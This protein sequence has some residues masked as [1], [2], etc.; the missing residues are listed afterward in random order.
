MKRISGF[1]IGL[2][3]LGMAF[4][5]FRRSQGGWEAGFADIGVWWAVIAALLV[6][7]A[8]G[9]LVGTWLHTRTG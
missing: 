9:A 2:L 5:A 6:I 4:V 8:L 7:A 3:W 1:V